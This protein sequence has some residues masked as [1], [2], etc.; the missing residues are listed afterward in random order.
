[1]LFRSLASESQRTLRQ[2][3]LNAQPPSPGSILVT[4]EQE[5][6]SVLSPRLESHEAGEDG[7]ALKK[8]IAVGAGVP[9]HF[10]AEPESENKASAEASGGSAY[11]GYEQRQQFFLDQLR[12]LLA[13]V[14]SRAA[15][16]NRRVDPDAEIRMIDADINA[17]DNLRASQ[18]G[19]N[20]VRTMQALRAETRVDEDEFRRI[21]YRFLGES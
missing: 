16:A 10:L 5:D 18:A 21:V 7:I 4:T 2:K 14:V 17:S 12:E 11:R 6:W 8:M 1:M 15:L 19:W 13:H 9:L 20:V 3:A